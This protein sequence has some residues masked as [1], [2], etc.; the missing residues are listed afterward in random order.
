MP[1]C[2]VTSPERS[3]AVM[4]DA[5]TQPLTDAQRAE[6]EHRLTEHDRNPESATPWEGSNLAARVVIVRMAGPSPVPE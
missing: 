3:Y 5:P 6:I 1:L 2:A 4:P